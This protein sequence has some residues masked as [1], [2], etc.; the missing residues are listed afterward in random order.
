MWIWIHA[1]NFKEQYNTPRQAQNTMEYMVATQAL[2]CYGGHFLI[3]ERTLFYVQHL[4]MIADVIY[5]EYC[6]YLEW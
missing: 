5:S 4:E 1:P 2:K 6:Y 3:V